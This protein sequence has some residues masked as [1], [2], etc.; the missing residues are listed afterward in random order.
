[1]HL[2][3]LLLIALSSSIACTPAGPPKALTARAT[4]EVAPR[5]AAP[6]APAKHDEVWRKRL[7]D[8]LNPAP[9]KVDVDVD[10]ECRD[11]ST[12]LSEASAERPVSSLWTG[13]APHSARAPVKPS[14]AEEEAIAQ[15]LCES[16]VTRLG[17]GFHCAKCPSYTESGESGM[18][19]QAFFPGHFS[20][21]GRDEVLVATRGCDFVT[22]DVPY[23]RGFTQAPLQVLE[24]V[25]HKLAGKA[26]YEAGDE[27]ALALEVTL[28]SRVDCDGRPSGCPGVDTSPYDAKLRVVFDGSTFRPAKESRPAFDRLRARDSYCA[29]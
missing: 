24:L 5:S 25:D 23:L 11:R 26:R 18:D 1:M 22:R 6:A 13:V 15:L 16:P 20:G 2:R 10:D 12:W 29:M 21:P 8:L 17:K 3:P 27:R 28:R 7:G 4:P 14:A 9:E 19:I